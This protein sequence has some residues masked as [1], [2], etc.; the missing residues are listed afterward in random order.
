MNK[1]KTAILVDSCLD[2][3]E[4]LIQKYNM[5]LVPVKIVYEYEEYLDNIN[6]TSDEVA[7]RLEEEIPKTSLP[8]GDQI[9]STLDEIKNQGY[10]KV[11]AFSVSS[12]LSGTYNFVRLLCASYVG[13]DVYNIDTKNIAIGGGMSAIRAAQ[14]LEEGIS[15]EE[16]LKEIPEILENTK[17]FFCLSTLKYLKQG[18]RIGLLTALLGTALDL[19]PIISCN[20]EGIYY[21][22]S[23]VRGRKKSIQKTIDLAVSFAKEKLEDAKYN[24]AIYHVAAKEEMQAVKE[25][26]L[27][28]LPTPKNI[29]EGQIT[30]SLVVH[31][32]PGLIG[33]GIQLL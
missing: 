29:Y 12:G 31:T 7:A 30:P 9:L 8:D 22:V 26:V 13:L 23:K 6:I 10:E 32:G 25:K 16:I 19:K 24:L 28:L 18:G 3:P 21:S 33:V 5:Y 27:S 17:V 15:T 4:E 1:Q 14:L 2:V 11:L 20:D